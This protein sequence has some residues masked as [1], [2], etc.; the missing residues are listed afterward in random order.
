MFFETQRKR[1]TVHPPS[2]LGSKSLKCTYRRNCVITLV[3][4]NQ[5]QV[6]SGLGFPRP[7]AVSQIGTL[8]LIRHIFYLMFS[9]FF[10]F[11]FLYPFNPAHIFKIVDN[12]GLHVDNLT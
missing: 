12:L 5:I 9:R 11:F 1:V 8:R 2:K 4:D 10:S 3:G 7:Q 6:K